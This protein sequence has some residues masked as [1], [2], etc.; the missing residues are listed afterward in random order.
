LLPARVRVVAV[1][2]FF[3]YDLGCGR[4][5]RGWSGGNRRRRLLAAV[6][7]HNQAC[8]GECG[9]QRVRVLLHVV[10]LLSVAIANSR[11]VAVERVR[12]PNCPGNGCG[13]MAIGLLSV[14][15]EVETE[16][17]IVL[18]VVL[19]L[20]FGGGGGYYGY[21][22]WGMGGGLGILLLVLVLLFLFGR[23]RIN[24]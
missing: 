18:L 3:Y 8:Q 4:G 17:I 16:M 20:V 1:T 14:C 7:R 21:H 19:L 23:G 6:E 2:A 22:Q 24:I 12:A 10:D 15:R 11:C 13:R 9:K 5:C